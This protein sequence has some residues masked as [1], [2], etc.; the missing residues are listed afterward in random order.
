MRV[1]GKE[2]IDGPTERMLTFAA[3]HLSHVLSNE[4]LCYELPLSTA[5]LPGGQW[6]KMILYQ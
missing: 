5:S 6:G 2:K 1:C 3:E 4:G